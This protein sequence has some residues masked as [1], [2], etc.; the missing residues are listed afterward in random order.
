MSI[1]TYNKMPHGNVKF[2]AKN[3]PFTIKMLHKKQISDTCPGKR[4]PEKTN[5]Q[6]ASF[7][8]REIKKLFL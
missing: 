5:I 3:F 7:P 6:Q 2:L 1:F 4:E 8:E